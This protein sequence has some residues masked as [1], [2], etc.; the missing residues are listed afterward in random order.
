MILAVPILSQF[1]E[2]WAPRHPQLFFFLMY[3]AWTVTLLSL[4][5]GSKKVLLLNVGMCLLCSISFF[6][7]SLHLAQISINQV[8]D[9]LYFLN[10]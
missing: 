8:N 9:Y 7:F 10:W 6:L 3:K 2:V 1:D 4:W 5:S